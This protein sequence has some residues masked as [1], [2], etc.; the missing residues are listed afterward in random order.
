MKQKFRL[1]CKNK[2]HKFSSAVLLVLPD[3]RNSAFFIYRVNDERRCRN[4]T[5]A[6]LRSKLVKNVGQLPMYYI[7]DHHEGIVSR[8]I[9]DAV[10]AEIARRNA[11]KSPSKK[12]AP[13][14]Q[15][16][17]ASKYALSERLVCGECVT[18]YRR[19]TWIRPG[20]KRIVWRC[21][22]R[23]DYG[24]KYCHNSPTLDEG[25]LQQA[26]LAA[27]SSAMSDKDHLV[28]QITNAMQLELIQDSH[29]RT[30]LGMIER[31]LTEL[32]NQFQHLL[33]LAAD[34]LAAY[35]AQ[36]KEILDEQTALKQK[37]SDLEANMQVQNENRRRITATQNALADL[38]PR[39]TEWDELA[40]RQ[41]VDTVKVISKEEILVTLKSGDEIRQSV[42][43]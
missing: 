34:D 35:H 4:C 32:E 20:R 36:F 11:L 7:K 14:G 2:Y 5:S 41:L 22:S 42:S 1:F 40:I 38:S 17:H 19:C 12:Y 30:S 39:I 33:E 9:Y 21:V 29:T 27:L 8:E 13:T 37:R 15:G 24:K 43:L 18:L 10:Q 16:A 6:F 25:P 3:L 26:I 23:L 31:R 28:H